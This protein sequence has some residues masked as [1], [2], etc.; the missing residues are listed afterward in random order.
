MSYGLTPAG[1]ER[2]TTSIC[3]VEKPFLWN[4]RFVLRDLRYFDVNRRLKF[5][6]VLNGDQAYRTRFGPSIYHPGI[7]YGSCDINLSYAIERLTC[8]RFPPAAE[9][10]VY[11]GLSFETYLR[12]NQV[13]AINLAVELAEYLSNVWS[14]VVVDLEDAQSV[15]EALVQLPHPKRILRLQSFLGMVEDG[16]LGD[17]VWKRGVTGK[18]KRDE[19]GKP[20]KYP[21]LINDLK[22][23]ASLQGAWVTHLLK[24]A[25][26]GLDFE[27]ESLSARFVKQPGFA[28]LSSAFEFLLNPTKRVSF[29]AFSDDSCVS[30]RDDFG[31]VRTYNMDISSCDTSHTAEL[32]LFCSSQLSGESKTV[33]DA[34]ISQCSQSLTLRGSENERVSLTPRGPVLFSGTTL[35]TIINTVAN[36]LIA[37]SID[38]RR[39]T[40]AEEVVE[41]ARLCGYVVT[42]EYCATHH[43]VQFLKYSPALVDGKYIPWL[44]LGVLLRVLGTCRGDLPGRNTSSIS[45]RA[46]RFQSSLVQAFKHSGV[47][48]LL[49]ALL[50]RYHTEYVECELPFL[51]EEF[52]G[53]GFV[54]MISDDEVC[55]R[56]GFPTHALEELTQMLL[57]ASFGDVVRSYASD[58]IL[59][60]D[61]GFKFD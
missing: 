36:F 24:D 40:T 51:V 37:L 55:Q 35:T 27:T 50:D 44:N 1:L 58:I 49:S 15:A 41:A 17:K 18:V 38:K 3:A 31:V 20:G 29:I 52:V 23:E 13:A 30:I 47:C 6:G 22:T 33:F 59:S 8:A 25:I 57:T 60:K 9:L 26:A 56:Y 12:G 7:I 19:W 54:Y 42:L 14:E 61:Y 2:I 32:F 16:S 11:P 45:D 5:S 4:D 39:A 53:A 46:F 10:L 28:S 21:R 34:L 43:E 48:S